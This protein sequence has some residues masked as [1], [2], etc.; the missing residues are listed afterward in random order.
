MWIKA[1]VDMVV[2][3]NHIRGGQPYS[4]AEARQ[5]TGVIVLLIGQAA[6]EAPTR[7]FRHDGCDRV[8]TAPASL[9]LNLV[10]T[11]SR[12]R[13]NGASVEGFRFCR[14][15]GHRSSK[16]N[17]ACGFKCSS[18]RL[19]GASACMPVMHPC[20]ST[21][22]NHTMLEVRLGRWTA[23]LIQ[24]AVVVLYEVF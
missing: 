20:D 19:Y 12:A 11:S 18:L 5:D 6:T 17:P 3:G 1:C 22:T 23:H 21:T 14:M 7:T 2:V 10:M 9:L 15:D 13:C 4:R 24:P 8:W 16:L